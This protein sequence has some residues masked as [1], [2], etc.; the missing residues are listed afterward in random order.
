MSERPEDRVLQRDE[1]AHV[2]LDS[3]PR[4]K[5]QPNPELLRALEATQKDL[6][7]GEASLFWDWTATRDSAPEAEDLRPSG[8]GEVL[9]SDKD[10]AAAYVPP[11][12]VAPAAA[13]RSATRSRIRVRPD[14][15][16]RRQPTMKTARSSD[17]GTP[18]DAAPEPPSG[19][20]PLESAPPESPAHRSSVRPRQR[21]LAMA[22]PLSIGVATIVY[23]WLRLPDDLDARL[24]GEER[25]P[26]TLSTP[27]PTPE[28]PLTTGGTAPPLSTASEAPGA[29]PAEVRDDG[30]PAADRAAA[31]RSPQVIGPGR[32]PTRGPAT[33]VTPPRAPSGA[34]GAPRSLEPTTPASDEEFLIRKKG[35][36]TQ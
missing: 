5:W 3:E 32:T 22:I 36:S 25:P 26:A 13:P 23:F 31:P 7:P 14:I 9:V 19:R 21:G 34:P 16:P 12:A 6:R 35:D 1:D 24:G 11:K 2:E 10:A 27:P 33:N 29:D 30:A 20:E 4:R 17:P 15:D 28:T 18:R 8:E